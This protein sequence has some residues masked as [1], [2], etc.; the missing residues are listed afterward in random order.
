MKHAVHEH[1]QASIEF[2]LPERLSEHRHIPVRR[3]EI[4]LRPRNKHEWD[5]LG[6]EPLG[7]REHPFA[8]FDVDI[9]QRP[10][11]P[12]GFELT[13]APRIPEWPG[14]STRPPFLRTA[15]LKSE[16]IKA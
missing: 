6:M 2:R 4:L 15:S 11:A 8:H 3:V 10:V 1:P 9:E 5:A 13:Q 14:L 7:H 12:N 16:A